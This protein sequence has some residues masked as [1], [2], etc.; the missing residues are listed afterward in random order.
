MSTLLKTH[1]TTRHNIHAKEGFSLIELSIIITVFALLLTSMLQ[2]NNVAVEVEAITVTEGRLDKIERALMYYYASEGHLPCPASRS[3]RPD[4]AAYGVSTDCNA[5]A[6]AGTVDVGGSS[7]EYRI[8]MGALPSRTIGLRDDEGVDGWSNKFSYVII[9]E[10]GIGQ[11]EYDNYAPTQ[12]SDYFQVTDPL[13]TY[14]DDPSEIVA[15]V[16]FSHGVD[17]RGAFA[18]NGAAGLNCGSTADASDAENCDIDAAEKQFLIAPI[19]DG[20][21][22]A[23]YYY[24][25]VRSESTATLGTL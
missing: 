25:V 19:N 3:A 10:L 2:V 9:R 12:T 6:P 16:V 4:N 5:A 8:R 11:T 13:D 20:A 14:G 22:G 17:K 7:D 18:R 15:Y 23:T 21:S 1:P 24:D